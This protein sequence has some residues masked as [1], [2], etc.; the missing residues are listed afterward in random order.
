MVVFILQ[1]YT[2]S[3]VP[4]DLCAVLERNHCRLRCISVKRDSS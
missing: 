3:A 2:K 4:N 1:S